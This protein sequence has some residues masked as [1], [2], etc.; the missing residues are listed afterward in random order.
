M[1][2]ANKNEIVQSSEASLLQEAEVE[3]GRYNA[4]AIGS[5]NF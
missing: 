3:K 4:L 2:D 1:V 5:H